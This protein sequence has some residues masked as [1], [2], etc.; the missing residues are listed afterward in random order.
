MATIL[1]TGATGAVTGATIHAL[2]GK[3]HRLI[4]LTRD[5]TKA[6]DLEKLGVELKVGDLEKPRTVENVFEGVD[7]A[8]ILT[9]PGPISPYQS[10]AALW[11][12]RRGKVKHVVRMSAVGAAHDAP[13]L[14]GRMHALSDAELRGSGIPFTI[15]KPHFFMQ[16][17]MMSAKSVAEQGMLYLALADAKLPMID[18]RDIGDTVAKILSEPAKHA[19]QTYTLTGAPV[20]MAQVATAISEALG[21]PVKYQP[22]P[23][24]AAIDNIAKMGFGDFTETA[25]RDYFTAYSEGWQS[26]PTSAVKDITGKEPRSIEAFARD[27]ASAFGKR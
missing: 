4:G 9:P 7:I 21:K 27:F 22:V 24:A 19:G 6:R 2:Q 13:S 26:T 20:S 23:V 17:L 18:V 25:M 12:A 5:A 10:S 14:N 15:V 1:L 8:W 16:N 3:G 11:G